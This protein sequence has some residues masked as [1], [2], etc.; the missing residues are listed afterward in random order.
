MVATPRSRITQNIVVLYNYLLYDR[1]MN[2]SIQP[3][4][5]AARQ[6]VREFHLLDGRVECCG[7][8]LSESHLISELN[9]VGEATAS[10]LCERLVLEKST[11]SRLVNRLV[12]KG[13]VCS[14]CCEDDKRSRLLCLTKK[15]RE[16]ARE[17]DSHANRQVA[18]A[19]EFTTPD[20]E[21]LI[22][23]GLRRYAAS[24]RYARLAREYDIRP[25]RPE[26]NQEVTSVIRQVMTEF[27]ITGECFPGSDAE[28]DAMYEAYTAPEA[29]FF[30]VE[31]QGE[32]LGCGGMG[33]L[34]DGREGDCELRKMYFLPGIRGAG[35]GSRLLR[36]ILAAA[37]EA[38][39]RRCYLETMHNM[40]Q[41]RKLYRKHGFNELERRLGNTGHGGCNRFMSLD[42]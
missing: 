22:I 25:I 35:L 23:E 19:L 17:L 21:K 37:R 1:A 42:L 20:E 5:H 11:M 7:L 15:G 30:V 8:P 27:G 29:A 24:L 41:A 32:I 39:Y 28:V 9:T 40:D 26:D 33:P 36:R 31:R 12:R 2:D 13:L 3:I 14:A 16:H 18:S 6:L 4:R 38:G 10:E 34:T